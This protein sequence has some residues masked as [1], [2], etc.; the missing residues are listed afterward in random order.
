MRKQIDEVNEVVEKY[1]ADRDY[2]AEALDIIAGKASE[3]RTMLRVPERMHLIALAARYERGA[4]EH[5]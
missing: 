5:L 2:L 1:M 4:N 3:P